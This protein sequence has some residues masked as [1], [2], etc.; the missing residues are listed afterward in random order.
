MGYF[1]QASQSCVIDNFDDKLL[2]QVDSAAQNRFV[3]GGNQQSHEMTPVNQRAV[4]K[5]L[6]TIILLGHNPT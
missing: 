5:L 2:L 6:S 4:R 1:D 3:V